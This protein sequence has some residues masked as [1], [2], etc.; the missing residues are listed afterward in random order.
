VSRALNRI[1][2][3]K[4]LV[5]LGYG[6]GVQSGGSLNM[7]ADYAAARDML[8]YSRTTVFSLDITEADYHTLEEGLKKVSA[9][10]GGFY[11]NTYHFPTM[12]FERLANT[13]SGRYEIVVKKPDIEPGRH[14]VD[15]RVKPRAY[16][17]QV[18]WSMIVK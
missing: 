5:M 14:D 12:A 15:V 16:H 11:V 18:P 2:G 8:A 13:L 3:A 6:L 4:T 7:R 10:T 9:D 17:V 1:R